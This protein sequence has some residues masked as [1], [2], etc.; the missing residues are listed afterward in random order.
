VVGWGVM[1][2]ASGLRWRRSG[3][4]GEHTHTRAGGGGGGGGIVL[5]SRVEC[6]GGR[7]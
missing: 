2:A 6:C 3:E 4:G 7:K 5:L 1:T